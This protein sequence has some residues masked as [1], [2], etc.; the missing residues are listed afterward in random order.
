MEGSAKGQVGGMEMNEVERKRLARE[1]RGWKCSGCGGRSN[2]DILKEEGGDAGEGKAEQSIPEELKFGFRDQMAEGKKGEVKEEAAT[3]AATG[4]AAESTAAS[5][6]ATIQAAP[7]NNQP[8]VPL[9]APAVVQVQ[10]PMLA[11]TQRTRPDEVPA[12]VDKAITGVVAALMVMI[13]KKIIL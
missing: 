11:P 10:R 3:P 9:A 1:S 4:A 7:M 12:W 5:A 6:P 8:S 2:E 13:I